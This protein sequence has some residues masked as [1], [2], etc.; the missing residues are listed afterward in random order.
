MTTWTSPTTITQYAESGAESVHIPWNS[1]Q[2]NAL[3]SPGNE[4]LQTAGTLVHTARSPKVD[5]TNKTYYIAATNFNFA[6]LPD[7]ISGVQLKLTTDRRG[8][9]TDETVHL[10]LNNQ[11]VGDNRASLTVD[12]IKVYGSE[13]DLWGL[14]SLSKNDITS[15]SFGVLIRF[16]SHPQW[17]HKDG[18]TLYSAE[19]LI[20]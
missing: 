8:R 17:P 20:S 12:P 15:S 3:Q 11:P 6:D 2:L 9:I 18:A 7:Q 19:L 5:F 13:T 4:A 16:Q 14:S 10:L 1:D